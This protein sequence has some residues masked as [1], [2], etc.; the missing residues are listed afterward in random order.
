MTELTILM[1]CL[2]EA[3]T[4]ET[5]IKKA[6][7]FLDR[8]GIEG[9]IVVADNGSTDGS[10]I[11]AERLGAR[12]VSVP[13]RGYG[14]ALIAGVEA[15]NGSYVIMGD[16]DDSY[17]FLELDAFVEKL[18]DGSD[19]VMGNRFRGG[20]ANGAMPALHRYFGNPV[21]TAIGRVLY[22]APVGDF[23]CGLR[24]FS[25]TAIQRLHL[26]TPGMEFASEMVLKAAIMGL[27]IDEV[28]TTLS[29]DG[30]SRAPHL[31]S[32]RDGWRHLKLLLTY[33]PNWLFLFPGLG[34][35]ALGMIVYGALLGGPI[36]L[37]H[38]TFDTATLLLASAL[39]L[40]G[41]QMICFYGLARL[42]SV[43]SGM[44]PSTPLYERLSGLVSVDLCCK[45]GGIL[46][47]AGSL[48]T[49]WAL[50]IWGASGW[51]DLSA[52]E[53]AR[54]ASF[55]VTCLALGVQSVMAGFLGG[56]LTQ[57]KGVERAAEDTA[58]F[59]QSAASK[60]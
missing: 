45:V 42:H 60:A 7:R 47:L 57:G 59:P 2:N 51:G 56:F 18:R 23:H 39:I 5:C 24:G 44:L 52:S 27:R 48:S 32:W 41:F 13:I 28:P 3:E 19:L 29:P 11:I 4:L 55:A 10:Q 22:R 37:G 54:P 40:V 30:R 6:R 53:I 36:T 17:N 1:P 15:A 34:I 21:L 38:V 16:S 58:G 49:L 8:S 12:V 9:E 43:K 31:R 35:L 26:Q 46:F 50:G 14:A 33:A 25:R 20:I